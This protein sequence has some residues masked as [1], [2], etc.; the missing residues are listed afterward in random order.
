MNSFQD[1]W[2]KNHPRNHLP[3]DVPRF[4]SDDSI[5]TEQYPVP[6]VSVVLCHHTLLLFVKLDMVMVFLDPHLNVC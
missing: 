3:V 6:L 1:L 5:V 2:H 4:T